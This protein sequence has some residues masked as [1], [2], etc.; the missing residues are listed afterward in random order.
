MLIKSIRIGFVVL[1]LSVA[2]VWAGPSGI[3][4]TV[5]DS[6]GQPIRGADIRIETRNGER[7]IRTVKTDVNGRYDADGVSAGTYRITL[8]VNGTVK[9]SINNTTVELGEPTQLNFDLTS[10]SAWQASVPA[11]KG[12]HWVWLPPFTGSRLPGRWIEVD[13]KGSWAAAHASSEDV[14]RI[15]GEELQRTAHSKDIIRGR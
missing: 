15:S 1:V 8:V 14:I 5:K 10:T 11:K 7:L 6:K 12:K 9:T 3:Q 4:G 2:N 13:D